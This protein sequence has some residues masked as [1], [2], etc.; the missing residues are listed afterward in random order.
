MPATHEYDVADDEQVPLITNNFDGQVHNARRPA[1]TIVPST[2]AVE[3][4]MVKPFP[5]IA[6]RNCFRV[7][8][9]P[10]FIFTEASA[11]ARLT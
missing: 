7:A 5:V 1:N 6:S 2:T 10:G 9:F 8:A 4:F 11:L 3:Y